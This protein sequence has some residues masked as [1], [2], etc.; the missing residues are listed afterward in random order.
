MRQAKLCFGYI[1]DRAET[2]DILVH[3]ITMYLLYL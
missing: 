2:L 3:D 1:T